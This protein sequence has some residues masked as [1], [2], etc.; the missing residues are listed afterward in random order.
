M[1]MQATT[2]PA[3]PYVIRHTPYAKS[4]GARRLTGL[5]ASHDGVPFKEGGSFDSSRKRRICQEP[6]TVLFQCF[7]HFQMET[8][9]VQDCRLPARDTAQIGF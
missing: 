4:L 1:G 7:T 8:N 3:Q 9:G 5:E 6:L 2:S